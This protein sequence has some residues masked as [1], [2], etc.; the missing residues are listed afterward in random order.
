MTL[1]DWIKNARDHIGEHGI[2]GVNQ[3]FYELHVGFWRR[4]GRLYQ[5]G[6]PVYETNWDALIILDACR[7]DLME[8][9][10]EEYDFIGSVNSINSV[11]SSSGEWM[12]KTFTEEYQPQMAETAYITGNAWA[13][14]ELS[15]TDFRLLD[16]VWKY[17]WDH[18]IG[19]I[20][21]RP[22]TDRAITVSRALD[23]EQLII[24]YMQPHHPYI[25]E[26]DIGTNPIL[27]PHGDGDR[28]PIWDDIRAGRVDPDDVWEAYEANLRYVLDDVELLLN[29]IDA[30]RVV[31]TSDHGNLFGELGLWSHMQNIPLPPVKRVPWCETTATDSGQHQPELEPPSEDETNTEVNERLRDLGYK[32]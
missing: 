19:T 14:K 31:I 16:Q 22:L 1:W 20:R 4:V 29:N 32:V 30:E 25:P 17:A 13:E 21:P 9:V 26:P 24:H 8:N 5:F 12:R 7:V 28:I 11:G 10:A 27:N 18:E 23:P 15:A 3:I 2:A 6:K